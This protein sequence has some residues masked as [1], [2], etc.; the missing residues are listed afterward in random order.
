[1]SYSSLLEKAGVPSELHA[2]AIAS[3][4]CGRS[5][6]LKKIPYNFA[7]FV[8]VPFITRSLKWEDE[9]LPTKWSKFD[10]EISMNGD[11]SDW[12]DLGNGLYERGKVPLED[13]PEIRARNYW[14]K[15]HH[16]RE[17]VSR[18]AFLLRNRAAKYAHDL[19]GQIDPEN[20]RVWGNPD[21][22]NINPGLFVMESNGLWQIRTIK[23]IGPIVFVQNFGYKVNNAW[24]SR[25]LVNPINASITYIPFSFKRA[26]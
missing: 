12:I 16:Q 19:G 9:Y 10:N 1:M 24:L 14:K 5:L 22:T 4:K 23:R 8:V 15:G 25:Q 6:S 11:N 17:N 21:I 13:T 7:A 18:R 2:E 26:K 20:R 3:L